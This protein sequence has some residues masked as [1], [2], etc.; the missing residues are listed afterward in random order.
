MAMKAILP[1]LE[2]VQVWMKP[3]W[4]SNH[5]TTSI[6]KF[7]MSQILQKEHLECKKVCNKQIHTIHGFLN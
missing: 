2:Q 7:Q 5:T 3:V 6:H 4:S 1:W